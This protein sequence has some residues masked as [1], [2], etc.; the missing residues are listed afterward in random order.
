MQL[1]TPT[2][3]SVDSVESSRR[4]LQARVPT[5]GSPRTSL[6]LGP[7]RNYPAMHFPLLPVALDFSRD[8]VQSPSLVQQLI[9]LLLYML[10]QFW[11]LLRKDTLTLWPY[12]ASPLQ[13]GY[14]PSLPL[15]T[16]SDLP[17]KV[18]GRVLIFISFSDVCR[19]EGHFNHGSRQ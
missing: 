3:P 17:M 11:P 12:R 4:S 14:T 2:Y 19:K 6:L 10:G 16:S 13:S 5:S 8:P 15:L 1:S 9:Q 18:P 7:V